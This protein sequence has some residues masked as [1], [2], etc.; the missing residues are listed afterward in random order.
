MS[1]FVDTHLSLY[2]EALIF[3]SE[4]PIQLKEMQEVLEEAFEHSIEEKDLQS[5]LDLLLQKYENKEFAYNIQTSNNGYYFL[6]KPE[7]HHVIG[8]SLKQKVKK[9]LS[10]ASMETLSIIVYKQPVTKTEIERIRG[11]SSDH[12]LQKLLEKDLIQITGRS[13]AVGKPLLYGTTTKFMDYL[14]LNSLDDLP[15]L[16]DLALLQNEMGTH[17]EFQTENT[18]DTPQPSDHTSTHNNE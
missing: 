7:Y 8:I 5:A 4:S 1:S 2:L 10:Q 14:G 17:P 3:S 16:K 18:T 9:R 15:K 13:E 11:V 6:P 12:S